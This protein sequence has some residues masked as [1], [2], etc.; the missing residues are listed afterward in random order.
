MKETPTRQQLL[1][2]AMKF[3]TQAESPREKDMETV[4]HCL[5]HR[6]L[7]RLTIFVES[8]NLPKED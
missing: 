3:Y 5:I 6:E 2:L 1:A 7:T 4:F 8:F